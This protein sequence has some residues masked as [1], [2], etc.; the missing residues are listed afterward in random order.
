MRVIL[1]RLL[2]LPIILL[3]IY[4]LTLTLAATF[5]SRVRIVPTVAAASALP[6]NP[7]LRNRSNNRYA[8]VASQ[9]RN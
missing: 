6:R 2:Q 5:K 9:N 3:V 8:R 7:T 1:R 4:T